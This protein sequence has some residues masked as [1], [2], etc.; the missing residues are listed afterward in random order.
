[1]VDALLKVG[2][3]NEQAKSSFQRFDELLVSGYALKE[4][5]RGAFNYY[6][7][8]HN[9]VVTTGSWPDS[10]ATVATVWRQ[11]NRMLTAMRAVADCQSS[12]AK[13][14]VRSGKVSSTDDECT[15]LEAREARIWLKTKIF[16]AWK[17]QENGQ[18]HRVSPLSCYDLQ[19][20]KE[21]LGGLIENQPMKC[22]LASCC[23]KQEFLA[24]GTATASLHAICEKLS[25]KQEMAKRRSILKDILRKPNTQLSEKECIALGDAVFAL[26]CPSDAVVLTTNTVDH[27]PLAKALGKSV[28][29][30]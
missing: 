7:W 22:T 3:E 26:Q 13:V 27:E 29:S 10:I 5:K 9:K 20:P 19:S 15:E 18:F 24:D 17:A 12:I 14:L 1:L 28:T 23:L 6:V 2:R 25:E 8:L 16:R 11:R 21:S 30:P 4:F